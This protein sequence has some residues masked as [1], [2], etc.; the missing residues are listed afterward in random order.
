M[1]RLVANE[2]ESASYCYC[3]YCYLTIACNN[4]TS[5]VVCGFSPLSCSCFLSCCSR[6]SR[7]PV[8]YGPVEP[9]AR[10]VLVLVLVL[11]VN[12]KCVWAA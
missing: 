9:H 12:V 5:C 11:L 10:K 7:Q 3:Y 4:V 2:T 8:P 1:A 6:P